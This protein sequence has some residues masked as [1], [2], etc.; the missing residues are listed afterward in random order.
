MTKILLIS[1]PFQPL[2]EMERYECG[3]D[4][5]PREW[6]RLHFG[7]EF[8]EFSVPTILTWNGEMIVREEWETRRFTKDDVLIFAALPGDVVT[9]IYAVV[10]LVVAVA[11]YLLIPDPVIPTDNTQSK[12]SSYTL[13]G[14]TNKF[15]PNEPIEVIYGKC[16]HW[17]TYVCRPYSQYIGNEQYQYSLFCL[18]QGKFDIEKIQLDDTLTSRFDEIEIEIIQPGQEIDLFESNVYTSTEVANI[19]LLGPNQSGYNGPAGPFTVNDSTTTVHR[20]AVDI[21]FPQGLYSVNNKGKLDS[22]SVELLF[23]YRE[24]G[25]GGGAIGSWEVLK[26]VT[27]TRSD[28]TPQRITYSKKVPKGRY[29]VRGR[30]I[31]NKS[32]SLKIQSQVRWET[33]KAYA[34]NLGVFPGVTLIAM[35]ALATNSLND[36]TS[37]SFNVIATRRLPTWT[38]VGGWTSQVATRNPIWAFCDLFRSTYGAKLTDEFLDMPKLAALAATF[39]TRND[40]FDWI[41]DGTTSVWEAAKMILRVGRTVPIPQGSLITAVRDVRQTL[42]S[43]IFNQHN[44]VKGSLSKKLAMFEFQPYDGLIVEY[45]EPRTWK[46]KEVKCVFP[47][48]L[49]ANLDRIKMPGCTNRSRAYREGMYIESRRKKQRKT[50]TFQTGMEGHIPTFMDLISVTHDTVRVGQGGMVISYNS[51]TKVMTL[52]EQVLFA[53][54]AIVHKIAIRGDNGAILG[55]PITCTRGPNPNQVILATNPTATLNFSDDRILPLYAFGV[56]DVWG[57]LGKVTSIKPL[58]DSTVEITAVNYVASTYDNE[59]D[60]VIEAIERPVITNLTSP[61]VA[62]VT[63]APVPEKVDSAFVDWLPAQGAVSYILQTS[64]DDGLTWNPAGNYANPPIEIG[65]NQ[66]TLKV[67]VAPFSLAGNVIYTSSANYIVGSNI[68]LLPP[69]V[70]NSPQATFETLTAVLRWDAVPLATGYQVQV[71]VAGL[72]KRTLENVPA[73][74]AEY[75]FANY[76]ADGGTGRAIE[77]RIASENLGGTGLPVIFTQTNPIPRAPTNV[78]LDLPTGMVYPVRWTHDRDEDFR[79]FRLY[80]STV[81]GFTAGPANLVATYSNSP[82]QLTGTG[83]TLFFRVAALDFWG[84]ELALSE[85]GVLTGTMPATTL[86]HTG[87]GI[88]YGGE[89]LTYS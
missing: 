5:T 30:R 55:S 51:T 21:S 23:E 88:T 72:L 71:Y 46:V 9:I 35:K 64:Y 27:V 68:A 87:E 66:A 44:I 7:E 24:I 36:N 37:K 38:Q 22:Y 57:F 59:D 15:R 50:V 11:A 31:T 4:M 58:D 62:W 83:N 6:L 80:A 81:S 70:L 65:T 1:N 25:V 17:P 85:E 67:R 61:Q 29:E 47:G 48:S 63:I 42:P 2:H 10:L 20:L 79:E 73:T 12:D 14:Q 19:E 3:Q 45:T 54:D 32:S 78:V 89:F 26:A 74:T 16:R 82:G 75:T 8:L 76:V 39:E 13:R 53:S 41:F 77:F 28:N 49:G 33:A 84:N 60:E 56:A 86:T 40:Y 52:S 69:P 18:G 34:K 43:A